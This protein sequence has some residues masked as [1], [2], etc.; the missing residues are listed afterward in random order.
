MDYSKAKYV[1]NQF[2]PGETILKVKS[3]DE[4][5]INNTLVITLAGKESS[6]RFILQKISH[7]FNSPLDVVKNHQLITTHLANELKLRSDLLHGR[8]LSIPFLYICQANGDYIFELEGESWRAMKFI[9]NSYTISSSSNLFIANEIGYGLGLFHKLLS[10]V[11]KES[12]HKVLD[13]FHDLDFYI[14]RY[15]KFSENISEKLF[16]NKDTYTR[17][18]NAHTYYLSKID[19]AR[20]Y[21]YKIKRNIT[22]HY[23]IHGDPKLSNFM[24]NRSDNKIASLIDLDTISF[25]CRLTDLSDCLR[26]AC[27]LSG[28]EFDKDNT[29]CFNLSVCRAILK[30]YLSKD[31]A[32]DM[33]N[34][35]L[36]YFLN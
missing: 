14:K 36:Y 10:D 21:Q 16:T 26:S 12:L 6:F 5:N 7:I 18:Q 30:G 15:L 24:L 28:G 29:P 35:I 34:D 22:D 17:V 4:G 32:L 20:R 31:I 3:I 13:H 33:N 19:Q 11:E 23:V 8:H 2:F 25:G 9:D 1:A 27:N